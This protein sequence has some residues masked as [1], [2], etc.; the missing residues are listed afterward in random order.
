M[1]ASQFQSTPEC[2]YY[3]NVDRA[4][5]TTLG[6]DNCSPSRCPSCPHRHSC[7]RTQLVPTSTPNPHALVYPYLNNL[8]GG[9]YCY[10]V[11][12]TPHQQI[13]YAVP[14]YHGQDSN[15]M[16]PPFSQPCPTSAASRFI[17]PQQ[18][19]A[20]FRRRGR[21]PK[22]IPFD[23]LKQLVDQGKTQD[24]ILTSLRQDGMKVSSSTL[25]RRLAKAGLSTRLVG[26][27][28]SF[29]PKPTSTFVSAGTPSVSASSLFNPLHESNHKLKSEPLHSFTSSTL[30]DESFVALNVGDEDKI[31]C[32]FDDI[33]LSGFGNDFY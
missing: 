29:M 30:D 28:D 20:S 15:Y 31:S 12:S 13:P 1:D 4:H 17:G 23:V 19:A 32:S 3:Q 21:P 27:K 5:T 22:E 11:V 18:N 2:P 8:E 24:E 25:K 14:I 33:S 9:N 7:A 10:Y 6:R 26:R 16:M